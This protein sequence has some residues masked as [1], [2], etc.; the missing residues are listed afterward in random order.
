MRDGEKHTKSAMIA[1]ALAEDTSHTEQDQLVRNGTRLI[2]TCGDPRLPPAQDL[3]W[4][5]LI[6]H[7]VAELAWYTQHR[8]SLPIYYHGCPGEEV[9]SNHSLRSTD[10]CLRLLDPDEEPKYSGY[11]VEQ[12]VADEV[13][14]V[15]AGREDA[16]ICK[17]CSNLTKENSR[18]KSLYLPKD[19]KV[20]AHHMKTKHDVQLTKNLIVFEY[21]RY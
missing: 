6:S 19:V 21:F 14:A 20:L 8:Y 10:A 17:I 15:I 18:W 1:V 5:I 11:K 13:A 7:V 2:C 9:L 4:G 12:S 16:P 3:S